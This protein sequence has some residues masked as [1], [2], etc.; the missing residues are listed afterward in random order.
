MKKTRFE[1]QNKGI[2]WNYVLAFTAACIITFIAA[3]ICA[4]QCGWR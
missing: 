4:V 2:D 3:Y 1:Y